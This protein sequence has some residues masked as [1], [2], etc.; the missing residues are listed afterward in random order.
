M[1]RKLKITF[2][3]VFLFL[4]IS[5]DIRAGA[6]GENYLMYLPMITRAVGSWQEVGAGSASGGGISNTAGN[7]DS[8]SLALAPDGTL[9][10][11]W[12]DDSGGDWE[13]YVRRYI[14]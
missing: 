5:V 12:H 4:L 3:F 6:E 10:A 1:N 13:I 11:A 14:E 9:Y 7:S 8:P 2:G